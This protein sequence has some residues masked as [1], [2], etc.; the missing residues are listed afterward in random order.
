MRCVQSC[1]QRAITHSFGKFTF[2]GFPDGYDGKKVA[3]D[4]EGADYLTANSKGSYAKLFKY[5]V[6][7]DL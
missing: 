3:A 2:K 5:V 4:L 7:G 1:P 6:H